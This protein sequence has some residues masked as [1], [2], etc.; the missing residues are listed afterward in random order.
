MDMFGAFSS[1]LGVRSSVQ[2]LKGRSLEQ[3]GRIAYSPAMYMGK[4]NFDHFLDVIYFRAVSA[5]IEK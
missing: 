1:G 2:T 4:V 5:M 3:A